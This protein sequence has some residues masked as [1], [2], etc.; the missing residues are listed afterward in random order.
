MKLLI[1]LLIA[2]AA[3]IWVHWLFQPF[4]IYMIKTFKDAPARYRPLDCE[5]CMAFWLTAACYIRCDYVYQGILLA[6]IAY[7]F[8]SVI[9]RL[10]VSRLNLLFIKT[11]DYVKA[12]RNKAKIKK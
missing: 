8:S 3:N 11:I 10:F 1:T 6:G 2:T 5:G 9:S 7:F 12:R 4:K